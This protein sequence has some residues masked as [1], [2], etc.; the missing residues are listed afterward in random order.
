MRIDS[1]Q[2]IR[3]KI[4]I[5]DDRQITHIIRICLKNLLHD[6]LGGVLGLLPIVFLIQKAQNTP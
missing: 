2:S 6:F 5:L 4:P 1:R 3:A